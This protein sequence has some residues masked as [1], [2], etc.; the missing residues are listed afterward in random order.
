MTN[1]TNTTLETAN[2]ADLDARPDADLADS[3][4]DNVAGGFILDAARSVGNFVKDVAVGAVDG[5]ING[6]TSGLYGKPQR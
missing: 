5:G 2:N 4:L 6:F 3:D 1:T